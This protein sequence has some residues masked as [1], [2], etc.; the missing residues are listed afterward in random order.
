MPD[1]AKLLRARAQKAH[2]VG[3][4]DAAARLDRLAHAVEGENEYAENVD[5]GMPVVRR[6]TD[7]PHDATIGWWLRHD[8]VVRHERRRIGAR[9]PDDLPAESSP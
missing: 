6:R 5:R 2:A 7:A 3:D 4:H 8:A 9:L 1:A